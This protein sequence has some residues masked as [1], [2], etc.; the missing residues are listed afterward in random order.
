M[1]DIQPV[2]LIIDYDNKVIMMSAAKDNGG[3]DDEADLMTFRS[4]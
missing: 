4:R 3:S 1:F 2:V